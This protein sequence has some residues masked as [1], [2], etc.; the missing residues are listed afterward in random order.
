MSDIDIAAV[1]RA[2]IGCALTSERAR[3]DLDQVRPE[4]MADPRHAA[5]WDLIGRM[6][7]DGVG[8]D[9]LSADQLIRTIDPTVR[10]GIPPAYLATCLADMTTTAMAPTYAQQIINASRLRTLQATWTRGAQIL[11]GATDAETAF[12]EIRQELEAATPKAARASFIGESIDDIIAALDRPSRYMPTPWA[13]VNGIIRGWRPGGLYVVAARPGAGK[14][15]FGLQAAVGLAQYGA[16]ALSSVEMDRAEVGRRLIA[17][18]AGVHF[19]RLQGTGPGSVPL[20]TGNREAIEDVREYIRELPLS[21][22]D[23]SGVTVADVRAHARSV[24]ARGDIAG[25]VVDYIG[26]MEAMRGEEQLP[27]RLQLGAISRR[28]KQTAKELDCPVIVL[29]QANR[30]AT[31][32]E[33]PSMNDIKESGSLEEDA[34]VVMLLSV[35][36]LEGTMRQ[37]DESRLVV[38]VPKNRQ[39]PL[40]RVVLGRSGATMTLSD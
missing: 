20:T 8:I 5:I 15:I 18:T 27:R 14:S 39:G 9:A 16:V 23:R 37:P 19:G 32:R 12:D 33:A 34:D 24:A 40:G 10:A 6:E 13:G 7:R 35:P 17:L 30:G 3:L 31:E 4:H 2:A 28:L 11:D 29:S 38:T 25:V 26:I 1:E 22:D 21:V 36:M